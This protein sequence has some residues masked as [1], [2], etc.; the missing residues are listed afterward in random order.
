MFS[1]P[2][3]LGSIDAVVDRVGLLR[4]IADERA[5]D[6]A[7]MLRSNTGGWHSA[8]TMQHWGGEAARLLARQAA[9]MADSMTIDTGDRDRQIHRWRADMWANVA[10]SGD[11][12][13]YHYHPGSVWSAVAYLDDGYDG[14]DEPDL[15]GELFFL[16]PRMPQ[17]RMNSPHLVLRES[18]GNEQLVEPFLRPSTGQIVVFP[19][20]LAHSVRPFRGHGTRI[21]VAINL[22]AD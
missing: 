14:S 9:A 5:R 10:R 13:Q 4:S 22:G 16:D 19:A 11:A 3:A 17:I 20:W 12:H 18:D 15:G 8:M 1:T 21:S 2:C 6:P 7:G